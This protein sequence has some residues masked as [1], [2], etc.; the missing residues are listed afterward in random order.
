MPRDV[1][2][3]ERANSGY[4]IRWVEEVFATMHD[5]KTSKPT[6]L[7]SLLAKS[8]KLSKNKCGCVYSFEIFFFGDDDDRSD[9][10]RANHKALALNCCG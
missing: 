5:V 6:F 4:G 2:M 9:Y 3:E 10:M 8:I 1:Q 7:F